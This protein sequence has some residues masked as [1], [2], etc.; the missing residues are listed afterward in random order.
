MGKEVQK[1]EKKGGK[2]VASNFF[3]SAAEYKLTA[4]TLSLYVHFKKVSTHFYKGHSSRQIVKV[5]LKFLFFF[6]F[7]YR[8]QK[9]NSSL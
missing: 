8:M 3:F 4:P 2:V 5:K 6:T 7:E 1:E 9:I